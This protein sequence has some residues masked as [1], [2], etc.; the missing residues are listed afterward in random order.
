MFLL[1]NCSLVPIVLPACSLPSPLPQLLVNTILSCSVE[2]TFKLLHMVEDA[3]YFHF[4]AWLTSLDKMSFHVHLCGWKMTAFFFHAWIN[5]H[6]EYLPRFLD[7][8]IHWWTLWLACVFVI[9]NNATI[10]KGTQVPLDVSASFLLC[11]YPVL[12]ELNYLVVLG[13]SMF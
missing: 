8:S 11:I 1:S 4:C 9:G 12:R 6:C 3:W 7:L 13:I 10:N 5:F 2:L